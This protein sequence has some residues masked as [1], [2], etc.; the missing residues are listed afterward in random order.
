LDIER[1]VIA[2]FVTFHDSVS[3]REVYRIDAS[4]SQE[5]VFTQS[6]EIS[7]SPNHAF[8]EKK[9]FYINL[10]RSVVQGLEG[11][12]PSNE[13]I[14]ESEFW[15]FETLDV[16]AP[17][18]TFLENPQVSNS[19]ISLLWESDE[20]ARWQCNL[21]TDGVV[22][23]ANCSEGN[24]EGRD[25]S[26]GF[27]DF[28]INATDLAGNT[29]TVVHTFEVDL[30]VPVT[31]IALK[32]MGLSN[33]RAPTFTFACNEICV[34]TCEFLSNNVSQD[35]TPCNQGRYHTP[36]LEH[37]GNYTFV[38]TAT[39][40][41]GNEGS[42]LAY[43]WE[44]D[45]ESP[46]LFG[47]RDVGVPCVE[48]GPQYAGQAEATDGRPEAVA[49]SH[50]DANLGCSIRRT[51]IARDGAGNT[52]HLV[53]IVELEFSP[54]V[55]LLP[56]VS[57]SCDSTASS[58]TVPT[59]TASAPNPCR[60][61]TQ[62][63][64]VDSTSTYTCPDEF[65]RN[66]T[67]SS[68]GRTM[69]MSQTIVLYDLCPPHACARNESSPHGICSL[70]ECRCNRPWHGL[71]CRTLIYQPSIQAINGTVLQEAEMYL[72]VISLIQG[73]PPLSWTLLSGPNQLRLDL[74]TDTVV[75]NRAQAGNYSISVQIENEVGSA[76]VEWAL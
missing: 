67:V 47:V 24:W 46:H 43:S 48:T 23:A 5:V 17:T 54:T 51:W 25:L 2:S 42:P 6:N 53:Q 35:A 65:T 56:R 34:F 50:S 30:I 69:F 36:S 44:T 70:G 26:G 22:G 40:E 10:E 57:H 63:T 41:V 66:W 55:S 74:D 72:E 19:N 59:A 21:V 33:Q 64:Y 18:I 15:T 61:P 16:T 1:P 12:G 29:A 11:C 32:P 45:F 3:E 28:Q 13:P 76:V 60:L 71:D 39:D 20:E 37:G 38:V 68:C 73:T 75:W 4:L 7:I 9:R 14:E 52:A 31:F 62:L 27:Y 49:V 8:E 58:I